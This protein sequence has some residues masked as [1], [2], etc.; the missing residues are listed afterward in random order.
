MAKYLN[1]FKGEGGLY[2]TNKIIKVVASVEVKDFI[3][4]SSSV[5][6][7]ILI[8]VVLVLCQC[9]LKITQKPMAKICKCLW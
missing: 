3:F 8:L 4:C 1:I 7:D 9:A 5:W 2:G 6:G